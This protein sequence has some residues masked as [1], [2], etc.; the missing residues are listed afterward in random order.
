MQS[1]VGATIYPKEIIAIHEQL[2]EIEYLLSIPYLDFKNVLS[3]FGITVND[4]EKP[5]LRAYKLIPNKQTEP[6]SIG[7]SIS[8]PDRIEY[9]AHKSN[10]LING[11]ELLLNYPE[12]GILSVFE[13]QVEIAKSLVKHNFPNK[14]H[15][16]AAVLLYVKDIAE[17]YDTINRVI[18]NKIQED[19][20][21]LTYCVD[22]DISD[23][24]KQ[25]HTFKDSEYTDFYNDSHKELSMIFR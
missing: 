1:S 18:K 10:V 17:T 3:F 13:Q 6:E 19:K 21:I 4:I 5:K 25:Y 24:I 2:K 11:C 12:P 23:F 8:N 16:D 22:T 9:Y 7:F 14:L 15:I 20:S